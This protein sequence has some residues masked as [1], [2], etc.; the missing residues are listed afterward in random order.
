MRLPWPPLE[1]ISLVAIATIQLTA[2][3]V[4]MQFVVVQALLILSMEEMAT[5]FFLESKEM[6]LSMEEMVTMSF[7]GK[8]QM[9]SSLVVME[10]MFSMAERETT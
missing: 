9:I 3:G 4:T 6:I 2:V 5:I 8:K 10:M 1:K 7:S